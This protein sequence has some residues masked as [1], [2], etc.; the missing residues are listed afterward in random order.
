MPST[1]AF[2]A[3][4][5]I[6]FYR[7]SSFTPRLSLCPLNSQRPTTAQV[8]MISIQQHFADLPYYITLSLS[9]AA[10]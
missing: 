9:S 10:I 7:S 3:V 6:P 1:V 8:D 2:L 4:L 5:L